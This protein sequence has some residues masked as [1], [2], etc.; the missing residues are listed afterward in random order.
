MREKKGLGEQGDVEFRRWLIRRIIE[1]EE[2]VEA[3]KRM[4]GGKSTRM[5]RMAEELL[6]YLSESLTEWTMKL[7]EKFLKL[8]EC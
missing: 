3:F 6:I 7:F 8:E 1:C 4:K 5:N 2:I